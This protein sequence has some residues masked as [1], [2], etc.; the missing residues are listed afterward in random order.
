MAITTGPRRTA[1]IIGAQCTGKTTLVNALETSNHTSNTSG[2][3]ADQQLVFVREVARSVLKEKGFSRDEIVTSPIRSLELQKYILEAQFKAERAVSNRLPTSWCI[4]DRSGLD[5][6]VYAQ[7]FVGREA[8]DEMIA[9]IA[10][11]ELENRMK[12]G[13][14]FVCEAGCSWLVDDGTRLM[15][16]DMEGWM[17]IDG[18]FRELL[19]A[20]AIP[21][22]IIS[23]DL[24]ALEDRVKLVQDAI[25][26]CAG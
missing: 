19:E 11:K 14:V 22:T 3:G 16:E 23:R 1:Y 9:S 13:I 4:C 8:A 5:P 2:T 24:D 17:Q 12:E 26:A 7:L 25:A 6:I 15:P 20:R 21:Y 10:W 18:A